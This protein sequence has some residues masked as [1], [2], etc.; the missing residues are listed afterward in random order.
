MPAQLGNR[1][2]CLQSTGLP[3]YRAKRG[4]E[5]LLH[6][7]YIITLVG[8]TFVILSDTG[9]VGSASDNYDV[10]FIYG[11]F[12]VKTR[13]LFWGVTLKL[14]T[15][16]K[17]HNTHFHFHIG[18]SVKTERKIWQILSW[19]R[20]RFPPL[21]LLY[22]TTSRCTIDHTIVQPKTNRLSTA[23]DTEKSSC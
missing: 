19:S 18:W 11:C 3:V 12:T 8:W 20:M 6:V 16:T 14:Q 13:V 2:A 23:A 17:W 7:V 21:S 4:T 9:R 15:A 22:W 5:R 10:D 1:L